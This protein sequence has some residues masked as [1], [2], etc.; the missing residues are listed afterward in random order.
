MILSHPLPTR[1]F[2][3][4]IDV[5]GNEMSAQA[6]IGAQ[7]PLEVNQRTDLGE[8]EIGS[9]PGFFEQIKTRRIKTATARELH[10]REAATIHRQAV[11]QLQP[12]TANLC[13]NGKFD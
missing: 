4:S 11:S 3:N 13:A 2:A 8:L 9:A 7:R 1:Y 5:S 10:S 6:A 12:P